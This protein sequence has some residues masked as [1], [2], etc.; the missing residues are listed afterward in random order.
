MVLKPCRSRDRIR[1]GGLR[2]R[3]HSLFW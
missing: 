2:C 1:P 3:R